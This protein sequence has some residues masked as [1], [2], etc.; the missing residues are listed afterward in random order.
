MIKYEIYDTK[1]ILNTHKHIDGGF[2]WEKYS[3]S[4]YMGCR[5][6]CKY[7][8]C[9]EDKYNPHINIASESDVQRFEDSFSQYVK[10]KKDSPHL[11]KKALMKK[12]VDLL[13]LSGYQPIEAKYKYLRSMLEVCLELGFPV[14]INE[15]SP[16]LLEDLDILISLH[17]NSH[18]NVGWSIV[19]ADDR[20]KE[21]FEPTTPSIHHRFEAMGTL[22]DHNIMTGTVLMPILPFINDNNEYIEEIIR[23][24][25]K[26]GGE[27]VLEGGLTLSG[28]TKTYFYSA[29]KKYDSE[30]FEKYNNLF[31]DRKAMEKYMTNLHKYVKSC[32]QKHGLLNYISRPVSYFQEEVRLN[33]RI[34]GK[35]YMKAREIQLSGGPKYREW[36]YRKAAWSLDD[37]TG[38][39]EDM[40]NKGG[41]KE[42]MKIKDIG[43]EMG[44]EIIQELSIKREI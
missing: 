29:L 26:Y 31:S 44:R 11:L 30:L 14:F 19:F 39:L 36:A 22:A 5:W 21:V 10:I 33:K 8:Y 6:G 24:T 28:Y 41:M 27:Y 12:P 18:V 37:L 15:K 35:F 23:K 32:C 25:K 4:P 34:A 20:I 9:R 16:L 40:Y 3:A 38:S 7:C 2:F 17:T 13:Y 43:Q 1:H 42:I